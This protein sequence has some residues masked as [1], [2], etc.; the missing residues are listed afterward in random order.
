M[1]SFLCHSE[2]FPKTYSYSYMIYA[3]APAPKSQ[4]FEISS[5]Y[6]FTILKNTNIMRSWKHSHDALWLRFLSPV[7]S[8]R[9]RHRGGCKNY[10][11]KVLCI[12]NL[13]SDISAEKTQHVSEMY[14]STVGTLNPLWWLLGSWLHKIMLH[15]NTSLDSKNWQYESLN[16]NEKPEKPIVCPFSWI[17]SIESRL[18]CASPILLSHTSHH[19]H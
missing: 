19:K 14:Q 11:A 5:L 2:F 12:L 3:F 17:A 10:V 7:F 18:R 8:L 9:A 6:D 16:V 1:F 4:D 13:V 15:A